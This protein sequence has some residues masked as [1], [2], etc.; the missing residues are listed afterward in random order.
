MFFCFFFSFY[1]TNYNNVYNNNK[2]AL[3]MYSEVS[4]FDR[5]NRTIAIER[6]FIDL[7][8]KTSFK[9]PSIANPNSINIY[10][11]R[12]CTSCQYN[13]RCLNVYWFGRYTHHNHIIISKQKRL[14]SNVDSI[15]P[16]FDDRTQNCLLFFFVLV[17]DCELWLVVT[18][19]LVNTSTIE[20]W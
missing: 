15:M 2:T 11:N 16:M 20:R 13:V 8:R 6:T 17:D 4:L 1:Y 9:P 3:A 5:H 7:H 14:K 10:T 12:L 18:R 19:W